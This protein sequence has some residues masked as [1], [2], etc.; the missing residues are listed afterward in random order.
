MQA[1]C[2]S[3]MQNHHNISNVNIQS[4]L[5]EINEELYSVEHE[6]I[7]SATAYSGSKCL[8]S[9]KLSGTSTDACDDCEVIDDI[10]ELKQRI[11]ALK[12]E[13][14]KYKM[15]V[16]HVQTSDQL[17]PSGGCSMVVSDAALPMGGRVTQVEDTAVQETKTFSSVHQLT[18]YETHTENRISESSK[19][20]D[21]RAAQNVKE[22]LSANEAELGKEQ[23]ANPCLDEVCHLQKK[24]RGAFPFKWVKLL[25][26]VPFCKQWCQR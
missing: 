19:A 16:L 6:D 2:F 24:L 9:P 12:S 26:Q 1:S 22:L 20:P 15:F 21:R 10:E 18:D 8:C 14:E 25:F 5:E 4:S 13:L 7:D 3:E 17:L 11:K 23:M